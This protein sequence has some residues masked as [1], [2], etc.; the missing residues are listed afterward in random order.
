MSKHEQIE[1]RILELAQGNTR[2]WIA[3]TEKEE[4][5]ESLHFAEREN[6]KMD[7]LVAVENVLD[8]WD[9]LNEDEQE[10]IL[11]AVA[12]RYIPWIESEIKP[13]FKFEEE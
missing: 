6:H 8:E 3:T 11:E 9:S 7:L 12:D 2:N 5:A 1:Q 13:Q 4:I 10:E